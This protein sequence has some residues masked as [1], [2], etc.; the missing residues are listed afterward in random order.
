MAEGYPSPIWPLP[1]VAP[2]FAT[3]S[4]GGGRPFGCKEAAC[5]RW[6]AGIDLTGA[7]DRAIVVAPEDGVVKNVD[8]GWSGAAKAVDLV[9]SSGL[10][11]VLGGFIKNSPAEFGV[12]AGAKVERGAELGRVLGS[13]GMIHLETYKA[14][15]T[16]TRNSVWKKGSQPPAGLLNPTN[17]VEL[18]AGRPPSLLRSAQRHQALAALGFY[19]GSLSALWGGP[20]EAALR[21]AQLSLGVT[22]DGV[23]GPATEEAIVAALEERTEDGASPSAPAS[24]RGLWIGVGI[25]TIGLAGILSWYLC[26]QSK[27]N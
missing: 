5:E 20:S 7:P 10:F 11:I 14:E 16:R 12:K 21:A 18:A 8:R 13:Y 15:P 4:F 26:E 17:Y 19:D 6:H 3:W 1:D 23:W 22:A 27:E 24:R 25:G 2:K 9:T